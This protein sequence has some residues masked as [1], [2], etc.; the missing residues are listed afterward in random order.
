MTLDSIRNSCDVWWHFSRTLTQKLLLLVTFFTCMCHFSGKQTRSL[1]FSPQTLKTMPKSVFPPGQWRKKTIFPDY[2]KVEINAE[3]KV[4]YVIKL[5]GSA[6]FI[7]IAAIYWAGQASSLW[8]LVSKAGG[9]GIAPQLESGLFTFPL[10][11]PLSPNFATIC[12]NLNL[13]PFTAGPE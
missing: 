12:D 13:M 11:C 10:W 4:R 7:F 2:V 8:V 5:T 9:W 3:H 1:L 6:Q